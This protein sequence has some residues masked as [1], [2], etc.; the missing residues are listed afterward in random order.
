MEENKRKNYFIDRSFQTKFIV[1]FSIV[2]VAASL[3]IGTLVFFLLKNFSAVA[4]ENIHAA[5]VR[6]AP[7]F[8]LPVV[9]ETISI[10]IALTGLSVIFLTVL[11]WHRI[12]GPLFRVN[13][14]IGKLKEGDLK[15]NFTTRSKDQLK[16]LSTSL[17]EMSGILL[18]KHSELKKKIGELKNSLQ[19]AGENK[20][21]ILKKVNELE[22]ILNYFKT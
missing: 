10:V 13:K 20:E 19:N 14:E 9:L 7:D 18:A 8:I 3:L 21:A 6:S 22:E 1:K 11:T 2:V 12:E 5:A 4:T 16:G 15:V 17:T